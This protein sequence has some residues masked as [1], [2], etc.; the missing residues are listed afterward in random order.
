MKY[1]GE[2]KIWYPHENNENKLSSS[3]KDELF[4]L[5][6]SYYSWQV[7]LDREPDSKIYGFKKDYEMASKPSVEGDNRIA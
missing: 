4:E 5:A 6:E 2:D 7:S 1:Q 3:L